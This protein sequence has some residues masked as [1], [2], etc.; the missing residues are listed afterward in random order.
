MKKVK[1]LGF[2]GIFSLLIVIPILLLLKLTPNEAQYKTVKISNASVRAEIADTQSKMIEGLMSKKTLPDNEGMLF[3]FND[4]SRHGIWM[5]NMNFPIDIIWIDKDL[6]I[7]DI[8]ED[9]Q[10]CK[11]NCPIYK[12]DSKALYVLE[13]NS[14]FV[15]KN[16]LQTGD[17]IR[18]T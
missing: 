12:P 17:S 9:A 8:A 11:F 4:E 10:P 18:I 15:S 2:L 13:V 3:I 16:K 5:M 1:F 7:I 6:K 14:G